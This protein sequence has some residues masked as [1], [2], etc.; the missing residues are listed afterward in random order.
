MP[1]RVH[2]Q[3]LGKKAIA[4]LSLLYQCTVITYSTPDNSFHICSSM[5]CSSPGVFKTESLVGWWRLML[6]VAILH[7]AKKWVKVIDSFQSS[8]ITTTGWLKM[9][10]IIIC[11]VTQQ[12]KERVIQANFEIWST[13]VSIGWKIIHLSILRFLRFLHTFKVSELD[14]F[15]S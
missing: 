15:C 14:A 13:G 8:D 11:D 1:V 4:H 5:T 10:T 6:S 2:T 7:I 9:S 3:H 12:S